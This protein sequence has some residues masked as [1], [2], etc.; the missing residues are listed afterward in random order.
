MQSGAKSS[1]SSKLA[2]A[3]NYRTATSHQR[4]RMKVCR[5]SLRSTRRL[6]ARGPA[7]STRRPLSRLMPV[8]QWPKEIS[9][10]VRAK[11]VKRGGG[12]CIVTRAARGI[13]RHHVGI[14]VSFG[15]KE[16]EVA[17]DAVDGSEEGVQTLSFPLGSL[18][19]HQQPHKQ[20]KQQS[21]RAAPSKVSA[22]PE[23][24]EWKAYDEGCVED[25]TKHLLLALNAASAP[26]CHQPY[27]CHCFGRPSPSY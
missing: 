18:Q 14:M 25:A 1:L 22:T 9:L 21:S 12:A 27:R 15:N 7:R 23:G 10:G 24:I 2:C 6:A 8:V 17:S 20:A 13:K 26:A 19:A 3:R 5:Q 4:S 16:S 11:R